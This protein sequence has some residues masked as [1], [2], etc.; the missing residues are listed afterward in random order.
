MAMGCRNREQQDDIWIPTTQIVAGPGHPFYAALNRILAD[1]GFD[2]YVEKLCAKFYA[3]NRGRPGIPP[4]VYFRM[5]MIGYLEGLDSERL[6]DW[7]CADSL[8]LREFLGYSLRQRTPDHSTLSVIRGRMDVET[9]EQVFSWVLK[10]LADHEL[11]KGK[12]VGVDSTTLEAN[13]ALRSLVQRDTGQTYEAYLTKLA[14]ESGIATPTRQDLAKLDRKRKGKGSND[15]WMNPHDPDAKI[16]KM[17]DGRTHLAHKAEHAVDMDTG[18]TLA[19]TIQ[20]AN[21][22]DTQTL[23]ETVLAAT[24]NLQDTA[25]PQ[26]PAPAIKELVADK[27]YHSNDVL[28]DL[29]EAG[30]RT[31]VSEPDRG[32]RR[33]GDREKERRAVH[34]NRRRIRRERGKRLLRRRGEVLE[35]PFAHLYETGAMRRTHLRTHE[36]ITTRVLIHAAASN[37]SLLMRVTLGIGKPKALQSMAR[38]VAEA[39][40]AALELFEAALDAMVRH[41]TRLGAFVRPDIGVTA[42]WQVTATESGE[43]ASSTGC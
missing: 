23:E 22:G 25:R 10:L 24:E 12:T 33:W 1:A 30:I 32:R 36:K 9:H 35:R 40:E 2:A 13:A 41:L 21:R 43:G 17:K 4:G 6:I 11:V 28:R 34:A 3:K 42:G 38:K 15:D 27:G 29:E 8:S 18:A 16:T 26:R 31:Y 7:R 20:A 5:L 37:L 19:V 14:R 39:M